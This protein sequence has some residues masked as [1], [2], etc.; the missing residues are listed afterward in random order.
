MPQMAIKFRRGSTLSWTTRNPVLGE[1][2]PGFEIDAKRFKVGDGVTPWNSL[3]YVNYNPLSNLSAH[4]DSETP[5]PIYDEGP[6]LV[7]LYENAKV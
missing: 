5:H 3:P 1:G 7:L 2:E 6:S 4:I